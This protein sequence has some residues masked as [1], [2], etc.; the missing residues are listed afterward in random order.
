MRN[1]IPRTTNDSGSLRWRFVLI[2]ILILLPILLFGGVGAWAVWQS[3]HG[4][5]L[6]WTIPVCWSVAWFLLRRARPAEVPLPEIGSRLHWTPQDQA[7]AEII[8]AEQGRADQAT[9]E[10]LTRLDF[11]QQR[12][13]ELATQLARHY[14]PKSD[15][16]LGSLSVVELLTVVQ[17]VAEDMEGWFQQYVPGSHLV[18][19]SQWRLLSQAPGW[20]NTARNVGW[21]ASVIANPLNLGRY[22]VTK[23]IVDPATKQLQSNLLG[24]CFMLYVRQVG[25]YLI[26]LNSGRLRGGS[27]RYRQTMERLAP[28]IAGAAASVSGTTPAGVTVTIAIVGQVKAGKSSLANC[29]LRD[30][31]AAVDVLPLTRDV[32]RYE[33]SGD[34]VTDR[35][36]DRLILLD[37]AG[38]SDSGATASQREA[39]REAVRQADLVLLVLDA[40]S[41]AKQADAAMLAEMHGWF[42]EQNRLKP[43][44]VIGVVSKV[45]GLSPLMEWSPPY[46]W[47]EPS[48]PKERS[49]R[50]AVDYAAESLGPG[51][52]AT[53]PVVTDR[54]HNRVYGIDEWLL[55][56]ISLHLEE[57]RAVSLVRT[58][59]RDYD[60]QRAWQVLSQFLDAG[61]RLK[62]AVTAIVNPKMPTE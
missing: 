29:L 9:A 4:L 38:Y 21:I 37:T 23:A 32:T 14:H 48:R 33:L 3:G 49:I 18:S 40:R 44:S 13:I 16:P 58:L 24:A 59:H 62:D 52:S 2:A 25:Y 50:A 28:A 61:R 6:S 26:E 15:D 34:D 56:T 55:P 7:A 54:E 31:Q 30:Q 43:P 17:L 5:W 12:T 27:A 35:A 36:S 51:L 46:H 45:D 60:Q 1:S 11:Y 22:V 47:E 20:W 19:V 8:V 42:K 57:A 53:V 10:Q 39:T 41:P